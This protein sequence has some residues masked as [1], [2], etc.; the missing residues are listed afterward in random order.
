[1]IWVLQIWIMGVSVGG[2]TVRQYFTFVPPQVFKFIDE[3]KW[4]VI[5]FNFFFVGQITN[6]LKTTGAFEVY[7]N[8]KLV[9]YIIKFF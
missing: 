1:M 7:A 3:K 8:N 9:K 6:W 4:I 2:Q 5:A